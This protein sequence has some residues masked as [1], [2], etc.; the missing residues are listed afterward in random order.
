MKICQ[1]EKPLVSTNRIPGLEHR[2][3]QVVRD[4]SS[5]A[6]AV[7]A[8]GCVADF[9]FEVESPGVIVASATDVPVSCT[10]IFLKAGIRIEVDLDMTTLPGP[11]EAYI[12]T[13]SDPDNGIAYQIPDNGEV[14]I[15]I[16]DISGK[17][18][19]ILFRGYKEAGEHQLLWNAERY[20][21]GV[22]LI[23]LQF[24]SKLT[25]KKVVLMK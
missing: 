3:M 9:E 21:S 14:V 6:V 19:G 4:G 20:S 24:N 25:T 1:V 17:E 18:V 10:S 22:Y 16:Y 7:D 23:Q 15:R 5:L 12:A 13:T 2:H 11:Y 8:V